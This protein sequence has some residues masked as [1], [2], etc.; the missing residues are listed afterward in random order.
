MV[1]TYDEIFKSMREKYTSLTG[2]AV[3]ENSD[4][5][6]R[7]RVLAGEIYANAV[8]NQWL[9][10][11]MFVNTSEGEYL[12]LH[13]L[14][15]GITRREATPSYGEVTFSL[16]EA[17]PLDIAIPKGTV[18]ATSDTLLRFETI[19]SS[20]LYAGDTQVSVRVRS[21][22][23]GSKYNVLKGEISVMVTP[24]SGIEK[25]RNEAP[26]AGGCDKESDLSLRKRVLESIAFP[27][28][29]TNCAYYKAIAEGVDGVGSAAVV[30][31]GRGVGTVDVYIAAEGGEASD[32]TVAKVQEILS[33]QREVNVDVLVKKAR[34]T[35]VDV[36]MKIRVKEGYDF[37][38]VRD[39]VVEN[40]TDFIAS[41]GTGDE[42]LKCQL[43]EVV[44]HTEGVKSLSF[45]DSLTGDFKADKT[46]FPVA[47]IVSV[48]RDTQ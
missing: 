30:A 1:Q 29:H 16:E 21:I 17:H 39:R 32:A 41:C 13:A 42:V 8:N 40:I 34:A 44:Y 47:G 27:S 10:R 7:L 14:E 45:A 18:L 35:E 36:Y 43:S 33:T 2:I 24:P 19:E 22:G 20:V 11:Q 31:R 25:V 46:A 28:N 37:D 4:I 5:G 48:S 26:L 3:E 23:G 9:K 12:E 38:E 6:I 15:R